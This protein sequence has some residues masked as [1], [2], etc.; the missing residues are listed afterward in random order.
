MNIWGKVLLGLVILGAGAATA[1]TARMVEV[2]NSW[3]KQNQNLR[4]ANIE[5]VKQIASKEAELEKVRNDLK[6]ALLNW[7]T[8]V[9]GFPIQPGAGAGAINLQVGMRNNIISGEARQM[10]DGS[11]G[12]NPLL[13]A[14]RP[15]DDGNGYAYVGPLRPQSIT[16]T[17][18]T[19]VPVW[20]VRSGEADPWN[21]QTQQWRV[22]PR[23]PPGA[24]TQFMDLQARLIKADESLASKDKYLEIQQAL[25]DEAKK[26][27]QVRRQELLGPE[28]PP[29]SPEPLDGMEYTH[30][31]LA[32]MEAEEE[33]RN[34]LLAEIDR[35][36]R[37]LKASYARLN[38]LRDDNL[39][40]VQ[41]LPQPPAETASRN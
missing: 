22:W 25:L 14:F 27:N 33:A 24:V 15:A 9:T 19:A 10:P 17:N 26:Q 5:N 18:T 6:V 12:Q 11:A 36:R 23:V 40:K 8:P 4:E 1:L 39:K 37:E 28:N 16:D 30:G 38:G 7:G 29:E 3:L 34:V 31:L 13:H 32:A 35:L 41:Q 20:T 21:A 2:R